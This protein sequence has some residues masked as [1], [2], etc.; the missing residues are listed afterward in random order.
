MTTEPGQR[1]RAIVGYIA[2]HPGCSKAEATRSA[3]I[4]NYDSVQR[5]IRRGMRVKNRRRGVTGFT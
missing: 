1:M 4:S 5:V 3:G 2:K